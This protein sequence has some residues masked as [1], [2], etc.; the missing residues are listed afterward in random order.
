MYRIMSIG[1]VSFE[2]VVGDVM[3]LRYITH[4]ANKINKD[5]SSNHR[6]EF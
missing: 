1:L 2:R 6:A 4:E 5:G 3:V